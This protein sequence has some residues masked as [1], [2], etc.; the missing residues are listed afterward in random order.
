MN[1]KQWQQRF[2]FRYHNDPEFRKHVLKYQ[3]EYR[4]S[5]K[6]MVQKIDNPT[7]PVTVDTWVPTPAAL[8]LLDQDKD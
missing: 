1:A 2:K 4:E 5:R 6:K 3:K 8:D 7:P